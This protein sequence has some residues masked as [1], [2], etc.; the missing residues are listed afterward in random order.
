MGQD[1]PEPL[2][3]LKARI[4]QGQKKY[5]EAIEIME[6]LM[7]DHESDA[8]YHMELGTWYHEAGRIEDAERM[9]RRAIALEPNEAEGYNALGYFFAEAGVK[10]DE[11]VDLIE[12]AL[13]LNPDKHHIL[14]SLGWAYYQQALYDQAVGVLEDA[15][16]KM[17]D[18]GAPSDAVILEH[19]G[20]AYDKAGRAAEAVQIWKEALEAVP[21]AESLEGKIKGR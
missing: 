16:K 9:L 12:K 15:V 14:D 19:L 6:R 3:R 5:D 21:E 1:H 11:A 8:Q 2:L 7:A 20:D 13:E 4:L 17:R 18:S 10:L